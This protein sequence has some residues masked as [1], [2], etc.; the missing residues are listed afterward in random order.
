MLFRSPAT[1]GDA[2]NYAKGILDSLNGLFWHDD[3]QIVDLHIGKYYSDKPRI[4]MEI[5]EVDHE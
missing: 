2:D 5:K 4:E 3:G 1:K